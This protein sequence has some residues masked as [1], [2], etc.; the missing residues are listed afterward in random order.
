VAVTSLAI[1]NS[2]NLRRLRAATYGR[3]IWEWNL[4]TA[5]A[6]QIYVPNS[7]I[8]VFVG[9][10][11]TF[12]GTIYSFNG[13]NS[14]VSLTCITGDTIAPQNC[15]AVPTPL[16][17][18][19]IGTSFVVNASGVGGDYV[20]DLHALGS[21]PSALTLDFSL[22]LHIV[23]FDLSPPAPNSVSVIPGSVSAPVALVVSGQGSFAGAVALSCSGL[24]AGAS[25]QFQPSS[26]VSPVSAQSLELT[27]GAAPDYSLAVTNPSLTTQVNLSASF[28]GTLTSLN[29]YASPVNLSCGPAPPAP[30]S[31]VANPASVTPSISGAPF[32][33]T[34]SSAIS[35]AYS[36]N[37]TGV[38][39]DPS[40]I[41]HSQPV[42]FTALPS[43][44]FDFTLGT[45]PSAVTVVVGNPALYSLDASPTPGTFPS[46]V[47]FRC[48]TLPALTTCAFN[49]A[50]VAMGNGD[51][52]VTLTVSTTAPVPQSAKAVDFLA[53]AFPFAGFL[54]TG[55]RR[56]SSGRKRRRMIAMLALFLSIFVWVS[57]GGLQGGGGGGSGSPEPLPEPI[58]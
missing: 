54:W 13:Y 11:A 49:P 28:N 51:S 58:T 25:C 19:P 36:F 38:G 57:C 47:T 18:I 52:V 6:F 31:C 24:P 39:S 40:A 35:Q 5:P 2:G 32:T 7:P 34:V 56:P 48:S 30:P 3:G 14:N 43:Q 53:L 4:V 21:D 10:T 37:I 41:T 42:N 9:Q 45:T 20:F 46:A 22:T 8:T 44:T 27:V 1:F 55:Q 15:A 29:S 23:D 17:P 12:N 26:T 50:Q 16:L 33:V